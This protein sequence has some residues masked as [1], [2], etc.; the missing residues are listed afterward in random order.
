MRRFVFAIGAVLVFAVLANPVDAQ[1]K[2]G[3]HAAMVSGFDT[4]IDD[5]LGLNGKFGAGG[6]LGIELPALPIGVYAMGTYY[7]PSGTDVSYY[8]ASLMAKLGLPLPI[9]SPYLLGG[10]QRRATSVG[11]LDDTQNGAF[12]G[13]GVAFSKLFLEG[14]MEFNEEVPSLPDLDTDPIVFKAGFLIG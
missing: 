14:S 4:A 1:L 10:Y 9:I 13:L 11:D 7:F 12:V 6:R 8:T 2:F 3:V 5:A